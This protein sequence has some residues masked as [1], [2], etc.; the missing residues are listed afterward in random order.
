MLIS[1]HGYIV[2][3]VARRFRRGNQCAVFLSEL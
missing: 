3:G 2:R 1:G